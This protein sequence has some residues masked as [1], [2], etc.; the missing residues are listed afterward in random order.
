MVGHTRMVHLSINSQS[1]A[2]PST[3]RAQC[4]LTLLNKSNMLTTTLKLKLK[5]NLNKA[6]DENSSL[7]Y[8]VSPAIWDHT[9]LPAT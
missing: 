6:P 4:R 5:I 8:G 7:S 3:N 9:V 2:D 1:V